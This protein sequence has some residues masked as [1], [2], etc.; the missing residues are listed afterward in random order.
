MIVQKKV[1]INGQVLYHTYSDSGKKISRENVKYDEAYDL[2][3]Y[4]YMETEET[5]TAKKD[6]SKS[7]DAVQSDIIYMK[8]KMNSM[9]EAINAN[10]KGI[11]GIISEVLMADESED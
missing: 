1:Y 11:D 10:A 4:D 6:D 9:E 7:Y 5:V 3:K 2:D 8:A